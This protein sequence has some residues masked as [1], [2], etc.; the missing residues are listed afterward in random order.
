MKNML[1]ERS[2]RLHRH[3]P[4]GP[5]TDEQLL[6]HYRDRRDAKAFSEL[7]HRYERELYNFL[8]RYLGDANMAEDAFQATFLQV[9]LKAHL[10]QKGRSFRPWVYT[11][12]THQAIDMMRRTRRYR[13]VSLD[14]PHP[15]RT[16][17]D[18]LINCLE[19]RSPDPAAQLEEKEQ[20]EWTRRAVNELPRHLRSVVVLTSFR[21]LEY[22]RVAEILRIPVGTVKTRVRTAK[23][24]LRTAWSR[25]AC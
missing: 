15:S 8:R 18:A 20:R 17:G 22:R 25:I 10:F 14:A 6:L 16:Q 9:H 1:K 3:C 24:L 12:A 23:D 21:G 4:P 13:P 7:V 11:I 5:V 19:G 2:L